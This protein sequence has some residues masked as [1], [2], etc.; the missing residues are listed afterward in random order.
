MKKFVIISIILLLIGGTAFGF[1]LKH[2]IDV[3]SEQNKAVEETDTDVEKDADQQE[4]ATEADAAPAKSLADEDLFS[5]NYDKAKKA[6]EDMSDEEMVGQLIVGVCSDTDTGAED[7]KNYSLAG[8]LFDS[9]AFSG[10]TGDEVKQ[11]IAGIKKEAKVAPIIA[12]E[13]EGGE[14]TTIS[15]SEAFPENVYDSPR[16]ILASGGLQEVEKAEL[17]KATFLKE[18]GFNLNFAPVVDM[19]DSSDQIMYS[20]S[21]SDDQKVVGDF[22]KY[23]AKQVQAKGVSVAL[24]HFPGYGAIPDTA[25]EE[26][27][28]NGTAVVDDRKADDIRNKDYEP[29]KQGAQ[30]GAHFIMVSNV[31]VKSI[32]ASHT[33]ALSSSVHKELRDLVGFSGLIITDVIDERDYSAYADGKD[34]AVAAIL[35]GNDLVLSRNYSTAYTAILS[36]VNDGTIS[37][38]MLEQVCTRVLAYKYTAG[39]IK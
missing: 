4:N 15:G 22:A 35:A 1:S 3:K 16:N 8:F 11:S 12:A 7:I 6:I 29:F 30:E 5:A 37:R 34:T 25:N 20:R 23:C 38:E 17:E 24:K 2:Y 13:E 39:M 31:V 9:E 27:Q 33:A 36:A 26:A 21:L 19:P 18:A 28:A 10:K 14:R 32:D